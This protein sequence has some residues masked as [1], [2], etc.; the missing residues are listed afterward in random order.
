MKQQYGCEGNAKL[1]VVLDGE[2]MTT[3]PR[4]PILDDPEFY[5]DLFGR[6]R[7]YQKGLF[8]DEGAVG[9]Q[10]N[11]L[12]ECLDEME[13]TLGVVDEYRREQDAKKKRA[14]ARKG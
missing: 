14:D 12:I 6:F 8:Y 3:C 4:R 1:P 10:P 11:L 9:S 13:Q 2:E 5:G 7:R